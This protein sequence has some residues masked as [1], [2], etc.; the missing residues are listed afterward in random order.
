MLGRLLLLACFLQPMLLGAQTPAV[1]GS[2]EMPAVA[3]LGESDHQSL[4]TLLAEATAALNDLDAEALKAHL[5]PGF[6]VTMV[7]QTVITEISQLKEY[8]VKYFRSDDSPV[9]SVT[10]APEATEPTLFID[11]RTGTVFGTSTDS[12]TLADDSTIVLDSHWTATVIKEGGRW[13]VQ[14]LHAGANI[15][16]NPILNAAR[17]TNY[18]W[19]AI[20]LFVGLFVG[21]ISYRVTK[22]S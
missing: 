12:Y 8:F 9:K 22:R 17:K 10:F 15:I 18:L 1:S 7:D 19:G 14:S 21:V 3:A 6:V 11:S 4:R 20:G 13:F 16:D 5:A 2:N